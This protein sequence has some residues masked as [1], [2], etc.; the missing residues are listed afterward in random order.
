MRYLMLPLLADAAP[1]PVVL[2]LGA[3]A[4]VAMIALVGYVAYRL[5][6]SAKPLPPSADLLDGATRRE[7]LDQA[8]LKPAPS[9]KDQEKA[10]LHAGLAKTRQ[11]G[12]VA[13][14]TQ[15]F[16]GKQLDAELLDQIEE[17]LF[18]ADLGVQLRGAC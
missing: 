14:L 17:V 13:R 5:L 3:L 4:V 6:R 1:P 16:A 8:T 10:Y 18:R 15:L 9:R 2:G 11:E 7:P 12:F